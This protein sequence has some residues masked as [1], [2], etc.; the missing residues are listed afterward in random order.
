MKA[1]RVASLRMGCGRHDHCWIAKG[2]PYLEIRGSWGRSLVRCQ[3]H[4]GE[5]IGEI[6]TGEAPRARPKSDDR[7]LRWMATKFAQRV[8]RL[9][10]RWTDDARMKAAGRDE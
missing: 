7:P 5:P 3:Q 10:E 2:D 1:W 9:P 6:Q 8:K 4:A